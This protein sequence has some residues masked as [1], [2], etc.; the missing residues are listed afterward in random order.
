MTDGWKA[1]P[2]HVSG[3]EVER[4]EPVRLHRVVR[5]RWLVEMAV[6]EH[7][8]RVVAARLLRVLPGEVTRG[9]LIVCAAFYGAKRH[10]EVPTPRPDR[11]YG[12]RKRTAG[13]RSGD[14]RGVPAPEEGLHR[15]DRPGVVRVV[16]AR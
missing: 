11:R 13:A 15:S 10:D 16:A 2:G 1:I 5:D 14:L 4:C 6:F 3:Q 12:P 9:D 7:E 8:R